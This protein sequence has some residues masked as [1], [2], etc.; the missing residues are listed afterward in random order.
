MCFC[1]FFGSQL[2]RLTPEYDFVTAVGYA[3]FGDVI[4]VVNRMVPAKN[5]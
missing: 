5:I 3:G 2:L 1:N 4:L